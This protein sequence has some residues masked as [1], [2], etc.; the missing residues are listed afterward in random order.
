LEFVKLFTWLSDSF[1]II[2]NSKEGQKTDISPTKE[3]NPFQ[4]AV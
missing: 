1:K 2:S 4:F 3:N